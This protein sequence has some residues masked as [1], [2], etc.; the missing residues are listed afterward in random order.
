LYLSAYAENGFYIADSLRG[1]LNTRLPFALFLRGGAGLQSNN[2]KASPQVNG[3]SGP[4]I[5][6]RDRI[7]T[8]SVGLARTLTRWAT[9]RVDYVAERR[10]SNLDRFDINTRA[11]TFQLGV[12]FF[13]RSSGQAQPTW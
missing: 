12:G 13:G 1:D 10:N 8:W 7:T 9:L 3:P 11:L 4:P 5:L 2:Y 6:R